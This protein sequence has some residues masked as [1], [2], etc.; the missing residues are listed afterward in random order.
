MKF[1]NRNSTCFLN[2]IVNLIWLAPSQELWESYRSLKASFSVWNYHCY[3]SDFRPGWEAS[4]TS[5][6]IVHRFIAEFQVCID[7]L[8]PPDVWKEVREEYVKVGMEM[9]CD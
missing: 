3:F 9:G 6:L 2:S 1:T 8:I 5:Y 4:T 7:A